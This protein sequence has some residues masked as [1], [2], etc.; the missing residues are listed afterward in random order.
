MRLVMV[1]VDYHS[2]DMETRELFSLSN[3]IRSQ[4][5]ASLI[6]GDIE[7]CALLSTC[8][9]TELYIS[10]TSDVPPDGVALLCA[11]LGLDDTV[12]R[13]F[14]IER[15]ERQAVTH[16][17]RVAAGLESIVPGDDQIVTQVRDAVE[18]ARQANASDP[19]LESLFRLAVT[20][21]KR[22]RTEACPA[23]KNTSAATRAVQALENELGPLAG[24]RAL[25]IGSGT[26][27]KLVAASLAERQC[28]IAMT[29][30]NP[31]ADVAVPPE[32]MLVPFANRLDELTRCDFVVSAT[33]SPH[34]TL[35]CHEVRALPARPGLWVDLSIPRDIDP[36]IGQ[37]PGLTLWNIDSL[38]LPDEESPGQTPEAILSIIEEEAGKFENWRKNRRRRTPALAGEPD[39]PLFISLHNALV[40]VAG[41]GKV[42]ARRVEKLLRFGARVRLV[43]PSLVKEMQP[44]LEHARVEW[45]QE[46]YQP[47]HLDGAT[48]AIAATNDREVNRCIGLEARRRGVLVSVADRR[49]ECSFYFPA[50]LASDRLSA[51]IVSTNGDHTLVRRAG[52]HLQ[53]QMELFDEEYTGGK[54]GKRTGYAAGAAGHGCHSPASS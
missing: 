48:L 42:A 16:L 24:K 13:R 14:F 26:I 3:E 25:I 23:R 44:H 39:F 2:A 11:A 17:M 1:G 49:Q 37:L 27:G 22:I 31:R 28:T 47:H 52:E 12:Y 32:C 43:S 30:R 18:L 7:G 6:G 4:T 54:Q 51:G 15:S 9:R 53:A 33:T 20:A 38:R 5:I 19:L 36:A 8:N 41:G 21:G 40:L 46:K 35:H 29:V 50:I 10:H 34:Y 45:I